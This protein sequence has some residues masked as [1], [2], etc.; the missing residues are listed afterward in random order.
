MIKQL[1]QTKNINTQRKQKDELLLQC[2]MH[3]MM[4][5]GLGV[6]GMTWNSHDRIWNRT[7]VTCILYPG[8]GQMLTVCNKTHTHL[9]VS[10]SENNV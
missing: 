6:G 7:K 3:F 1:A 8:L 5:W 9:H 2:A 10:F 4:Q